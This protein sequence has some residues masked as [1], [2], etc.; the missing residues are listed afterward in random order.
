MGMGDGVPALTGAQQQRPGGLLPATDMAVH[1][2]STRSRPVSVASSI[3]G[4]SPATPPFHEQEYEQRRVQNGEGPH[5]PV[6]FPLDSDLDYVD[7]YLR[8]RSD[9]TA[10]ATGVSMPKLDRTMTDIYND[11]LYSPNFTITSASPSP[12][13]HLAMSPNNDLFSQR[14]HAANSRHLYATQSPVSTDSRG[15]SPFRQGSPYASA[16]NEFPKLTPNQARLE[17]AQQQRERRKAEEDARQLQQQ[18]ARH[19]RQQQHQQ[20]NTPTTISPKDAVLEFNEGDV[21][22]NFPLFPP[23]ETSTYGLGQDDGSASM[24][25]AASQQSASPFQSVSTTPANSAFTFS[26]APNVQIPQQYP[27]SSVNSN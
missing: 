22:S 21:D 1:G 4:D 3:G 6:L 26:M 27:S 25:T 10:S 16:V 18:M 23:Q 14:I 9:D 5:S 2:S 24:N 11:E 15:R 17:S 7:E 20:Q 12:Q 13:T 19:S 8:F